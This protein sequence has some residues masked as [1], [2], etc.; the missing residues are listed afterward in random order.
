MGLFVGNVSPSCSQIRRNRHF[1]P[2]MHMHDSTLDN[3]TLTHI[4]LGKR[5]PNNSSEKKSKA[6]II[7]GVNYTDESSHT[8]HT[9]QMSEYLVK[10]R[11]GR[12]RRQQDRQYT[13]EDI[14]HAPAARR[15]RGIIWQKAAF[16]IQRFVCSAWVR[17]AAKR[18]FHCLRFWVFVV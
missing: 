6:N 10:R 9:P 5:F 16:I 14:R 7:H 15:L 12:G 11:G 13:E 18:C 8:A 17:S 3:H 1:S 2:N 4:T